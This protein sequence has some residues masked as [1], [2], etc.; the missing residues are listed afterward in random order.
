MKSTLLV[1]FLVM[2]TACTV[3]REN[4]SDRYAAVWCDRQQECSPGDFEN[5]YESM[6][7]C[8]LEV[9]DNTEDILNLTEDLL[10]SCVVVSDEAQECFQ[11]M[12]AATCGDFV[13]GEFD[14]QCD[15]AQFD[16]N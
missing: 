11:E 5:Q 9:A 1:S 13:A 10:G 6:K 8:K 12:R 2:L 16:C 15:T 4:Y 14:G 7:D 3:D